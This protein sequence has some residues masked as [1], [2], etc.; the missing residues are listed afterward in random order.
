MIPSRAFIVLLFAAILSLHVLLVSSIEPATIPLVKVDIVVTH[1]AHLPTDG[2]ATVTVQGKFLDF[3]TFRPAVSIAGHPCSRTYWI[4]DSVR[5]V[6]VSAS[7]GC[8][9]PPGYGSAD[10]RVDFYDDQSDLQVAWGQAPRS[11]RY[12]FCCAHFFKCTI[13]FSKL[14]RLDSYLPP[15]VTAVSPSVLSI[16]ALEKVLLFKFLV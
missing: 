8:E 10:L 2:G 15:I 9:S 1:A 12:F 14:M 6:K 7:I 5:S 13:I 11:V 4:V 3:M 16:P